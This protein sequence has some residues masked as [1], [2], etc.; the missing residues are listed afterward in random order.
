MSMLEQKRRD[1]GLRSELTT[2]MTIAIQFGLKCFSI[3][4]IRLDKDA[5]KI[6]GWD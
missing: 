3:Y 4:G 6:K 5:P 2:V 1:Q